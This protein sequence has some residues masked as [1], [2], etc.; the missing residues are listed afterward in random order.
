VRQFALLGAGVL[1]LILTWL[2]GWYWW[3]WLWAVIPLAVVSLPGIRRLVD[4][5]TCR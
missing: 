3:A 2:S 5:L 1:A 4:E